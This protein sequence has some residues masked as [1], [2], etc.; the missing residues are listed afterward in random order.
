MGIKLNFKSQ[1][2]AH[3]ETILFIHQLIFIV[4]WWFVGCIRI[5]HLQK[6]L[7][8]NSPFS[9]ALPAPPLLY[10]SGWARVNKL[11][12]AFAM[13]FLIPNARVDVPRFEISFQKRPHLFF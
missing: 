7:I 3:N 4:I 10:Y 12:N 9:P 13:I 1:G 6:A 11:I 2:Q 8:A 5:D